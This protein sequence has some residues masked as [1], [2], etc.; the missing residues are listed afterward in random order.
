MIENVLESILKFLGQ[1]ESCFCYDFRNRNLW[2]DTDSICFSGAPV[3]ALDLI[4]EYNAGHRK[5][6]GETN[7]KRV[8]L[9]MACDETE[10]GQPDSSIIGC[11]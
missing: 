3:Q 8:S 5:T 1:Q 7:F 4:G 9:D 6:S 10:N 11:G 2:E